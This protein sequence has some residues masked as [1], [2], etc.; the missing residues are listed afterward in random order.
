MKLGFK[1]RSC[2]IYMR[3]N[4][5]YAFLIYSFVDSFWNCVTL[6][7]LIKKNCLN[8]YYFAMRRSY[9]LDM[10]IQST[11][12]R[13]SI[14]CDMKILCNTIVYF[15]FIFCRFC[16]TQRPRDFRPRCSR[17]FCS[18]PKY[19]TTTSEVSVGDE[20]ILRVHGVS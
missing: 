12:D 18:L 2:A 11:K 20:R 19:V 16:S 15:S 3:I 13:L 4:I 10:K 8:R 6:T 14:L 17:K 5:I 9:F 7:V 1:K